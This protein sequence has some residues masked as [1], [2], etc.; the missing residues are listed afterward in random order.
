MGV[1][2]DF[3]IKLELHQDLNLLLVITDWRRKLL[4][5]QVVVCAE[6]RRETV[7]AGVME[8]CN[9]LWRDKS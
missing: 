3:E 7:E 6:S 2:D 5:D 4:A 8:R 9:E 1:T